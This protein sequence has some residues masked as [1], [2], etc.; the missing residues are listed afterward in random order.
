M[1]DKLKIQVG[2]IWKT[3]GGWFANVLEI[4]ESG[5]IMARHVQD[6]APEEIREHNE[7]GAVCVDN[8]YLRFGQGPSAYGLIRKAG[9]MMDEKKVEIFVKPSALEKP[10]VIIH[11]EEGEITPNYYMTGDVDLLIIDENTPDD[12][13]YQYTTKSNN[14]TMDFL[15]SND[16]IGHLGD[17]RNPGIT[18][19]VKEFLTGE[20]RL[21]IVKDENE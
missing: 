9:V 14:E 4:K 17:D 18:A 16:P 1:T 20:H 11:F 3:Y 7:F 6:K 13:V 2:E 15:L 5:H 12:R 10:R 21:K 19:R 8:P